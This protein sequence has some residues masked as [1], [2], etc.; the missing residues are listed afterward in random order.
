MLAIVSVAQL[1]IEFWLG[2]TE[3][4]KSSSILEAILAGFSMAVVV[5]TTVFFLLIRRDKN[6]K[7]PVSD[8]SGDQ[9]GGGCG[10]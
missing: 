7:G 8:K 4:T 9:T 6:G 2:K 5:V 10:K 1:L 3:R